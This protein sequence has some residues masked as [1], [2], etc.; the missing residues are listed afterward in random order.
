M[1]DTSNGRKA[2]L[3]LHLTCPEVGSELRDL[4]R[5][6]ANLDGVARVAPL[7][8]LSRV[9]LIEFDPDA[10]TVG[11]LV[12]RARRRWREVQPLGARTPARG[13]RP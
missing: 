13:N 10:I 11:T 7:A 2:S 1:I 3:A 9:V 6:F 4:L 12:E 5:E 8:K